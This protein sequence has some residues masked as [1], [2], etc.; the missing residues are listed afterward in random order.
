MG[1]AAV[2]RMVA[3]AEEILAAG[4]VKMEEAAAVM[5]EERM[6]KEVVKVSVS[7]LMLS[8]ILVPVMES[9]PK[10]TRLILMILT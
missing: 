7:F 10:S 9:D 2:E 4:W 3:A 6:A 1:G 5:V 8:L